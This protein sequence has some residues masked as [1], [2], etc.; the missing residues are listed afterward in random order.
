MTTNKF[1]NNISWFQLLLPCLTIRL[2]ITMTKTF[3]SQTPIKN[4]SHG[5]PVFC[6]PHNCPALLGQE[7]VFINGPVPNC[8]PNYQPLSFT[9]N[10]GAWD[11]GLLISYD[12]PRHSYCFFRD[13]G[14]VLVLPT[15]S[16]L[17]C[18]YLLLVSLMLSAFWQ[19]NTI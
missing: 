12:N 10:C 17:T 19:I 15:S 7:R 5:A 6:F 18:L 2:L 9:P 11:L 13:R 16:H 4:D 14:Y 3:V 8:I 1:Q